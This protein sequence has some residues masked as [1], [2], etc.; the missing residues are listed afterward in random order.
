MTF[1]QETAMRALWTTVMRTLSMLATLVLDLTF[2]PVRI[3]VI[4]SRWVAGN[5][6]RDPKPLQE[7]D[8]GRI[9]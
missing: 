9:P 4:E 8:K 1:H 5:Q 7:F 3:A 6:T 2:M